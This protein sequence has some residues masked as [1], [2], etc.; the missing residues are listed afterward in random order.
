[1]SVCHFGRK[2]QASQKVCVCN[3]VCETESDFYRR[4][5]RLNNRMQHSLTALSTDDRSFMSLFCSTCIFDCTENEGHSDRHAALMDL[6]GMCIAFIWQFFKCNDVIEASLCSEAPHSNEPAAMHI[7]LNNTYNT[8]IGYL[9]CY[10]VLWGLK[11]YWSHIKGSLD[12]WKCN[13]F[14]KN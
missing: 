10:M 5:R 2:E 8:Y 4:V 1:M 7:F 3:G 14:L 12:Q 13:G 9:C 11:H 6:T